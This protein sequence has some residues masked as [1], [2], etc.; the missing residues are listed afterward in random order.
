MHVWT[1]LLVTAL[2]V[3]L[4]LCWGV[5]REL[6]DTRLRATR[7]TGR[8]KRLRRLIMLDRLDRL[9][10]DI[11]EIEALTLRCK[12]WMH[13]WDEGGA[14]LPSYAAACR[15]FVQRSTAEGGSRDHADA[16][17]RAVLGRLVRGD[18]VRAARLGQLLS[19]DERSRWLK[20]NAAE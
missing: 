3:A 19:Q 4:A 13:D 10:R 2:V 9:E 18:P 17:V 20:E 6:R 8:V 14:S 1:W 7:L 16:V 11:K 12:T 15:S 5:S